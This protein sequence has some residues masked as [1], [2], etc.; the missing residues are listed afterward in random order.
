M[1]ARIARGERR[2]TDRRVMALTPFVRRGGQCSARRTHS[3]ARLRHD[4]AEGEPPIAV[5]TPSRRVLMRI[6]AGGLCGEVEPQPS[7]DNERNGFPQYLSGPAGPR[8][9]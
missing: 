8:G 5:S 4:L 1:M 7:E 3:G 2:L 6:T 9:A